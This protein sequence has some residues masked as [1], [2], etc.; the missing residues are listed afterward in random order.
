MIA[1]YE[2]AGHKYR[3]QKI[4]S[5]YHDLE[6]ASLDTFSSEGNLRDKFWHFRPG[7]T[8]FD[9]G[10]AFGN[11]SLP[12]LV[13][14]AKVWSFEP[15][16]NMRQALVENIKL[17]EVP[18]SLLETLGGTIE[19]K[20]CIIASFGL[21][22]SP[23]KMT[24]V[25]GYNKEECVI[26]LETLDDV[27]NN[28]HI[29]RID[30]IKIDTEGLELDILAGAQNSLQTFHPKLLLEVHKFIDAN[31]ET[32]LRNHLSQFGYNFESIPYD[33]IVDHLFAE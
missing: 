32:K 4:S 9:V 1:E 28:Y 3:A 30:M 5:P 33:E 25:P 16:I 23:N 29:D 6:R 10:S 7:D 27:V 2:F 12:A 24:Y 13:Q 26:N 19:Q 18:F 31:A 20:L 11:Y 8:V 21:A 14:G 15:D 17:N 22:R